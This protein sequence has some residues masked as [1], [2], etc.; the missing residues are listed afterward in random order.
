M[1]CR[2][3]KWK[4]IQSTNGPAGEQEPEVPAEQGSVKREKALKETSAVEPVPAGL[5][6]DRWLYWWWTSQRKWWIL[7]LKFLFYKMSRK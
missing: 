6:A 1:L 3:S 4:E 7:K 2:E 5:A